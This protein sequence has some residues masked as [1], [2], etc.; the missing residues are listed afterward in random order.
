MRGSV[1]GTG[2]SLFPTAMQSYSGVASQYKIRIERTGDTA[3]AVRFKRQDKA[4]L[5]D[6]AA[7]SCV[8]RTSH[9]DWDAEKILRTYWRLT[10][11]ENT[12]R[13][14]KSKLGLRPIW[15]STDARISA[16]LFITVLAC[17]LPCRPSDP[18]QATKQR[19]QSA[20]G[21]NTQPHGIIGAHN[22]NAADT[23][24]SAGGRATGCTP[25]R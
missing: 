5:A 9:T 6:A 12:F 21:F 14:L 15:H 18:N 2:A 4:E 24:R 25:I 3:T 8:L 17:G 19:Y 20:P 7:G 1:R 10:D 23:D 16:H 22:D 13:Q 11:L